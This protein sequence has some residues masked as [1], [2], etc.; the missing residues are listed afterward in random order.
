M[1]DAN[2]KIAIRKPEHLDCI[3]LFLLNQSAGCWL[4]D[5]I[6]SILFFEKTGETR[7]VPRQQSY[8]DRI[9]ASA[10]N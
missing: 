6:N 9:T 3:L 4:L 10:G 2:R 1:N 5:K 7:S 8:I